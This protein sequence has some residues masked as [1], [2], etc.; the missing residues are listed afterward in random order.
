M[1][2]LNK[3]NSKLNKGTAKL[4]EVKINSV[5]YRN[6][7]RAIMK[8]QYDLIPVVNK[9]TIEKTKN[10]GMAVT[11]MVTDEETG[12]QRFSYGIIGNSKAIRRLTPSNYSTTTKVA[13]E[14][15]DDNGNVSTYKVKLSPTGRYKFYDS[16]IMVHFGQ[17]VAL[18][19][20]TN[21]FT[22]SE[23]GVVH[24]N[25]NVLTDE[26]FHGTGFEYGAPVW[27]PSNEKHAAGFFYNVGQRSRD[28]WYQFSDDLTG[29]AFEYVFDQEKSP[30]YLLKQV[31]R[32][33]NYMTGSIDG[34]SIDLTKDYIV[35]IHG[36]QGAME[37]FDNVPD[38]INPGNNIQDGGAT[39]NALLWK[40]FYESRGYKLSEED[41]CKLS[42]QVRFDVIN[43]K[44]MDDIRDDESMNHKERAV[45]TLYGS[46]VVVYGNTKGRCMLI[47]D[48]DGAKL[49]NLEKLES[50]DCVLQSV[51]MAYA[52]TNTTNTS[53]QLLDKYTK[54]DPERTREI[55]VNLYQQSLEEQTLNKIE[56]SFD[57]NASFNDNML[58]LQG[59]DALNYKEIAKGVTEDLFKFGTKAVGKL[60]VK[61]PSMYS[62]AK[63]DN[64]YVLSVGEAGFTIYAKYLPE[65]DNYAVEAFNADLLE[66]KADEIAAIEGSIVLSEKG[67]EEALDK[68]LTC[69]T[70]KYPS[71]GPEEYEIIRYV[72]RKEMQSRIDRLNVS[73]ENL[74]EIQK[75]W[76]RASY[77]ITYY[78]PI[79]ILKNKLAGMDIDYDATAADFSDL[80]EILIKDK[81]RVVDFIDYFDKAYINK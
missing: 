10:G 72:T 53:G 14:E 26:V 60:N 31:T 76:D 24:T 25:N 66:E 81:E 28:D 30:E 51:I 70:I 62:H 22:V 8:P 80:K 29:G 63:F 23:D 52:K 69:V 21:G 1:S 56:S 78:A 9:L 44:V 65:Y 68:L 55:L 11:N 5:T 58:A 57:P 73:D 67:I 59:S 4:K 64:T 79:N 45:K 48:T 35:V 15:E 36:E 3:R 20:M 50:G 74:K 46:K 54:K 18:D 33:G 16:I 34:P 41:C 19:L 32:W 42:P 13:V 39:T 27:G 47:V 75:Y 17:G 12:G 43:D 71:A 40:E 49:L 61:I 6:F 37:D 38:H 2:K 7:I 77:G